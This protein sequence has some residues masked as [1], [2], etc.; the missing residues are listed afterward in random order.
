MNYLGHYVYNH[1]VCRLEPQPYFV[2]GVVLPDL[3]PRFSRR[4]RIRWKA[5]RGATVSDPRA[6]QLRD[7]LLNHVAVDRRFHGLPSFVRWQREL[8]R[9]VADRAPRSAPIDFLAHVA[10]ELMLD[11][12]LARAEPQAV[13]DI[14]GQIGLCRSDLVERQVGLL[15]D[16]D[17]RGLGH[18]IRRFISRRFLGQIARRD[19]LL[20]AVDYILSLMTIRTAPPRSTICTLLD[21]SAELVDP[22]TIW[23]EMHAAEPTR[24]AGDALPDHA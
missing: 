11:H 1:A 3:W 8:K 5:A 24:R 13:E 23:A 19:T 22:E 12:R 21:A 7:G 20:R 9:R 15:G 17:A 6:A 16:V 2:L 4:R 18:E 14:Y 10:V